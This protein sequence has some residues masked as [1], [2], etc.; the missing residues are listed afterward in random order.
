MMNSIKTKLIGSFLIII[1]LLLAVSASGIYFLHTSK[2][3]YEQGAAHSETIFSLT[4]Q[5]LTAEV[6][7]KT[8]VQEWK[9]ILLRGNDPA[10]YA[11]YF[12]AFEQAEAKVQQELHSLKDIF[13]EM[14]LDSAH[15]EQ[16][17]LQHQTLGEAYQNSLQSFVMTDPDAGKKVDKLVKGID[18]P[19]SKTSSKF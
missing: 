3:S 18:R 5:A 14:D 17:I 4:E 1:L 13:T 16:A 9:N 15:V 12:A 2:I 8:Q 11:N 6:S 7:F 10:Q 19:F